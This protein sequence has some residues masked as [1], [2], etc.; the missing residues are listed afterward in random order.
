M[1]A[2]KLLLPFAG[3]TVIGHIVDQVLASDVDQVY[4]VVGR[5][6]E[7]IAQALAGR[8]AHLV[9]NPEPS[10]EMLTSV[11][12]GLRALPP[13]CQAVLVALGDQPGVTAELVNAVLSA[14]RASGRGIVVP[15]YRGQRRHPLLFTIAYR[16]EVLQ[17]YEH[18]GL[19]GL[20][21]DHPED[22][23]EVPVSSPAAIA[24]I[25]HPEDYRR[26]VEE[27]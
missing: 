6:R 16:D 18:V 5:D 1:G 9:E 12:C 27:Q 19:R 3:S 20:L 10:S 23:F 4:V 14:H 8:P 22:V 7:A 15:V 17:G 2:Q 24:D 26:A 21:R 13:E 25:D 11:R